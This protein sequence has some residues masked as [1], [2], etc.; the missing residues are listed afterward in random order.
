M[1]CGL[2]YS[3]NELFDLGLS[4]LEIV[5]LS[6][7]SEH[8]FVG[9]QCGIMD[10]FASVMSTKGNVILLDCQS[11]EYQ[12]IPIDIHPYKLIMLN[13]MVSHNLASK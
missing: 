9:T 2:A 13:T 5:K 7:R 11:L 1:E 12:Q 3:L 8:T 6:Q 4:K 10:Q